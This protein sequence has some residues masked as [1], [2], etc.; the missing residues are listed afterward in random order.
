MSGCWCVLYKECCKINY[1]SR[2]KENPA[3]KN[4]LVAIFLGGIVYVLLRRVCAVGRLLA[5]VSV[6]VRGVA[7][8][9]LANGSA[10]Q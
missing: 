6:E 2:I 1:I 3:K 8:D 7:A 4:R 10:E 9:A 5:C